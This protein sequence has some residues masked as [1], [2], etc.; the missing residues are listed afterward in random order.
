MTCS[1]YPHKHNIARNQ[2]LRDYINTIKQLQTGCIKYY[3]YNNINNYIAH[4][5]GNYNAIYWS[6]HWHET[7]LISNKECTYTSYSNITPYFH[8]NVP[9][10]L[11]LLSSVMQMNLMKSLCSMRLTW[12]I[13][14]DQSGCLSLC[15][16]LCISYSHYCNCC[17]T[18]WAIAVTW[19]SHDWGYCR[20]LTA[21]N[22]V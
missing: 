4:K 13:N 20:K 14:Y 16:I 22:C 5:Y 1:L 15:K 12:L 19:S 8:I 6:I 10:Q 18:T 17:I 3:Q 11:E 21:E 9:N 2:C 7:G